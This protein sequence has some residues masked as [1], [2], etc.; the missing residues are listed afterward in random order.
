MASAFGDLNGSGSQQVWLNLWYSS[1]NQAGNYSTWG[2]ELYYYG[3]GWGTWGANINWTLSG[4]AVGGGHR[5]ISHGERY[6][7]RTRLGGGYFNKGHNSNGYLSADTLTAHIS[8]DHSSVGSGRVSVGTGTPPRIPKA[9][10]KPPRPTFKSATTN[11]ISFGI[12]SP[13]NNGGAAISTYNMQAATNSGFT[14]GVVSWNSGSSNQVASP[15]NPGT[16]YWIRY[17]ARNSIGASAWSDVLTATT[18]PSVAPGMSVTPNVAGTGVS[19]AISTPGITPTSRRIQYRPVGGEAIQ[20]DSLT[21]P[22]AVTDLTPGQSYEWRSTYFVND[23]QAPWTDWVTVTQPQPNTNPGDY[24]DGSSVAREDL[25][26]AWLGTANSSISEA[27]G[28]GVSGWAVQTS[29]GG[30]PRLQRVSGGMFGAYSAR[31]LVISD[32]TG[33]GLFLGMNFTGSAN[34]AEV[35][36]GGTYVGSLYVSPSRD[37]R[38]AAEIV[39]I[40]ASDAEISRSLGEQ[41]VVAAGEQ[42]RLT[43][44][45]IAPLGTVRAIVRVRDWTGDG[46][47]AWKGGDY[48]DA[49]GAMLTLGALYDYF[50]G[51]TPNTPE[52][53]YSWLG[54]AN[55]SASLRSTNIVA[56]VDPLADPDCPPI[57]RPPVPPRVEDSCIETT[58]S[59]RRYWAIISENEVYDWL[60]V[61]PTV[62]LTTGDIAAR[63]VRIRYYSNPDALAPDDAS[64]L[65]IEAEQVVS[66]MPPNTEMTLDGV[67]RRA[68][69]SVAGAEAIP[70]GQ[71]LYGR[72]GGPA[73]WPTLD[74]GVAYLVSF[75]VPLD[76]PAGNLEV[77]VELTTRMM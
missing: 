77:G 38:L 49:D 28:V 31:M 58:G 7:Q 54:S 41:L 18:M 13:G 15:L 20:R 5:H 74:C 40:N 23:Y 55:A 59:W 48:L 46:W 64:G 6:D 45:D 16:K 60:S 17:R 14:Q 70:A 50:D 34:H 3:N 37:Q 67:S 43:V 65:P 36:E 68:W 22:I 2:W 63:Q 66:Y 47:S 1:Y 25:S 9:P 4:F 24:F 56:A 76:A 53:S 30:S 19:V 51:A 27:R 73:T 8:S 72:D 33:A 29:A 62:T 26:F 57:P 32:A 44:S 11:S 35:A 61:V 12:K 69:A 52:F 42:V 39:W 10:G 71:L 75:D 21:T